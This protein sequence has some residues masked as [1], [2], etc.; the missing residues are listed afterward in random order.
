[1]HTTTD[2]NVSTQRERIQAVD[3]GDLVRIRDRI[4]IGLLEDSAG[5]STV[6]CVTDVARA[7]QGAMRFCGEKALPRSATERAG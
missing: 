4:E 6:A 7:K 1:M 5:A 3:T 2:D